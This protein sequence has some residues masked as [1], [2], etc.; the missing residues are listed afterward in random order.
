MAQTGG[1]VMS[2][3]DKSRIRWG[4]WIG[5]ALLLL[6]VGVF[7]LH[8]L[9]RSAGFVQQGIEGLRAA[10]EPILPEDFA[11]PD[12]DN[13][14]NGGV[15]IALA[16]GLV[17]SDSPAWKRFD[18]LSLGLPLRADERDAIAAIADETA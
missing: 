5:G 17:R 2:S 6:L 15:G 4:R 3:D 9:W 16:A 12:A 14:D 11:T 1:C 18:D 13:P 7:A 10:G 8:V